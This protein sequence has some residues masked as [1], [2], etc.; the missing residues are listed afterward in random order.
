MGKFSVSSEKEKQLVARM[1]RLGIRESD[2][3]ERFIKGSGPGGQKINKTSSCV[4]LVHRPSRTEIKCQASRSQAL[5]RFIARRELC[6]A[7]EKAILG[8]ESAEE[9]QREKI[10]RQKRRK[11]RKQRQKMVDDKVAHAKIKKNRTR[12]RFDD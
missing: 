12:V 10:R 3:D 4:Y 8:K 5:N 7:I 9:Q 2:I 11:S 6:D 1:T